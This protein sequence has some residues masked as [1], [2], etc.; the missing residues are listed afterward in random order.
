MK[1][2][3][4]DHGAWSQVTQV[5]VLGD[6]VT[7]GVNTGSEAVVERVCQQARRYIDSPNPYP[8]LRRLII[9][10]YPGLGYPAGVHQPGRARTTPVSRVGE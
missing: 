1:Q 9:N 7:I 2:I 3:R 6:T 4:T 8:K 10:S 5:W